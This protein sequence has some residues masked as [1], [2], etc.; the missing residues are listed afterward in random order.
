MRR[1]Y[2]AAD[3]LEA[4][5]LRDLLAQARIEVFVFNEHAH[6]GAGELPL[7]EVWPEIWL[8]ND[9][10]LDAAL[11]V[12]AG[13]ERRHG[14]SGVDKGCPRCGE[15]NPAGFEVCWSCGVPL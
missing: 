15:A 5:L 13:F 11:A 3:L 2:R 12:V 6:A 4:I 8:R 1:L 14:T 10:D 9:A 7:T